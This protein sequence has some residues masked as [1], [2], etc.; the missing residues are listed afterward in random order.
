[1]EKNLSPEY[2]V[3]KLVNIVTSQRT[4]MGEVLKIEQKGDLM[5]IYIKDPV[6][7]AIGLVMLSTGGMIIEVPKSQTNLTIERHKLE[8]QDV[9]MTNQEFVD[10]RK[11]K[12]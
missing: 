4:F 5:H 9:D 6:E 2:Y 10:W 8:L 11:K 7:L 3:G 12:R 1:M